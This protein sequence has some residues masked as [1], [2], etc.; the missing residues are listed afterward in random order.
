MAGNPEDIGCS[1]NFNLVHIAKLGHP[2]LMSDPS[3]PPPTPNDHNSGAKML[4]EYGPLLVF[5][6][7]Y[8]YLR[9]QGNEN[10]I[11]EAAAVFA[12]VAVLALIWS[13][14]KLGKFSGMLIATTLIIVV[15][16]AMA[17]G[18]E[19]KRFIYMKPTIINILF[20]IGT[21]GG[22]IFGKNVIKLMLGGSTSLPEDAWRTLALRWGLFF[23]AMAALNE[24]VW[25]TQSEAFWANFKVLGFIPITL[26]FGLMQI[27]LILKHQSPEDNT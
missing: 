15:T 19:D 22:L 6:L 24:F 5:V 27:P 11:F 8:N 2:A 25:R 16:V 10:A 13:R 20:G 26:I 12:V 4:V 3:L 21:L 9:I 23:F 14:I 18:F 7:L 17:W 1:L